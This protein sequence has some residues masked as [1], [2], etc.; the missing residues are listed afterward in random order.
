MTLIFSGKESFCPLNIGRSRT[1]ML[2][3]AFK[4]VGDLFL[5]VVMPYVPPLSG[6]S[7]H[8]LTWRSH[9]HRVAAYL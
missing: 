3:G 8:A 1:S 9:G 7:Y 6:R 4:A 5:E 2:L